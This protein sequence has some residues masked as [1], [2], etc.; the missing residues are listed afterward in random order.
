MPLFKV[1]YFTQPSTKPFFLTFYLPILE[2]KTLRDTA[3]REIDE[4]LIAIK[5]MRANEAAAMIARNLSRTEAA[6]ASQVRSFFPSVMFHGEIHHDHRPH[7]TPVLTSLKR[8]RDDTDE[9]GDEE[10]V[11]E[12]HQAEGASGVDSTTMTENPERSGAND[13]VM[14]DGAAAP[15]P[16]A[17][18]DIATAV[19]AA[20]ALAIRAPEPPRPRKRARR[21]VRAMAQTATAVTIGAVVTWSALA[22]S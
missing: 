15:I 13:V 17:S 3:Q 20:T 1:H 10:E 5:A 8:K 2:M 6:D 4:Q 18:T 19:A 11:V 22:F 12:A 16:T 14:K 21:F 7:Q 9:N